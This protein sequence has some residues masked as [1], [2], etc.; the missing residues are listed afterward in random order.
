MGHGCGSNDVTKTPTAMHYGH[1]PAD[2]W[3]LREMPGP[4]QPEFCFWPKVAAL[5]WDPRLQDRVYFK[6]R[7]FCSHLFSTET[8]QDHVLQEGPC[9]ICYY[10]WRGKLY[11][12]MLVLLQ[13]SFFFLI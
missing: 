2:G 6:E 5:P 12:I 11:E 10:F 7:N 1:I 13:N 3:P 4:R 9:F 8:C